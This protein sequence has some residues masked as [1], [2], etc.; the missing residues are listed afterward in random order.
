MENQF[1]TCT[2][3]RKGIYAAVVKDGQGA[4]GNAGF[5]DLGEELLV[6]DTFMIPQAAAALRQAAEE[7][8]GKKVKYVVNS[9]YHGDH[10]NGNGL[11]K[12]TVIISTSATR[13]KIQENYE[14]LDIS[15]MR[16]GMSGYFAQLE[17]RIAG[18]QNDHMRRALLNDLS[19]KRLYAEALDRIEE[20]LPTVLFEEKM[21]IQGSERTVELYHFGGGHTES[22]LFMYLPEEKVLY[23]GDLVLVNNHAWMGHGNPHE[24]LN[25]LEKMSAFT[26]STIIPGHGPV[27]A[28]EDIQIMKEYITD[29]IH[30][31]SEMQKQGKTAEEL[32]SKP[33]PEKYK[34]L[35]SPHVYEWNVNFLFGYLQQREE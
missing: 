4:L 10:T 15:A 9:H 23:A 35:E 3:V 32:I 8:T 7:Q 6:F 22:D 21:V 2:E 29:M 25:I 34:D 20:V 18:E 11:F 13:K 17:D 31:V 5:V 16:A 12:D 30:L 1:F 24:W 27:G 14:T 26:A 28:Y 19:D 33:L